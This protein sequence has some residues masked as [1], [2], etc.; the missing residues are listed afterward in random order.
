MFPISIVGI[1]NFRDGNMGMDMV[2]IFGV[3]GGD[4]GGGRCGLFSFETREVRKSCWA[5]A[6]HSRTHKVVAIPD[7]G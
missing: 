2:S 1:R 7:G 6:S 5:T 3:L 4:G